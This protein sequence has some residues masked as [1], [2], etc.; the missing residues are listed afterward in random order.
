MPVKPEILP[1]RDRG[2]HSTLSDEQLNQLATLLDDVFEIPGTGIRFGLDAILGLVPGIGD[3]LTGIASLLLLYAAWQRQ[4]PRVTMWR[5][6]ANI[7]ID[8]VLGA[9]PF[10][11]D[12][13]DVAWKSNRKN[14]KLLARSSAAEAQRQTWKDWLFLIALLLL[15]LLI[16]SVPIAVIVA[17]FRNFA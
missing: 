10:A 15:V 9:I 1:P 13:F 11:G 6:L 2:N 12:V 17:L 8:T 4:L 7:A 16:I 14:Y 5:M 3:L